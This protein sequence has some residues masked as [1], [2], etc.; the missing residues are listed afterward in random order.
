M[1]LFLSSSAIP[2]EFEDVLLDLLEKKPEEIKVAFIDTAANPY[3]P[4]KK[5]Y[6]EAA[7]RVFSRWK[8]SVTYLDLAESNATKEDLLESLLKTDLIWVSGGNTYYLRYWMAQ[9]GFDQIIGD[10][11]EKGVAYAGESAGS[12]VAGPTLKHF[13]VADNPE[14]AP[15]LIY[16]GLSLTDVVVCPHLDHPRF[17]SIIPGVQA[18]LEADGYNVVA[19]KDSEV[20]IVDN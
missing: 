10:L 2:V 19:L 8:A 11:L 13:E 1:K 14:D 5:G 20:F 4:E 6:L 15:E 16:E 9:S 18:R 17:L 12:I 7:K 3:P